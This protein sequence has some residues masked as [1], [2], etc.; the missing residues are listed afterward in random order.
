MYTYKKIPKRSHGFN[1]AQLAII[2][3]TILKE[4]NQAGANLMLNK[5]HRKDIIRFISQGRYKESI[6]CVR[7]GYNE[8]IEPWETI[9]TDSFFGTDIIKPAVIKI[10]INA[11]KLEVVKSAYAIREL[12]KGLNIEIIEI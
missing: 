7:T 6:K 8:Y 2:A 12:F 10:Q 1:F 3:D 9:K 5:Q 4:V 11:F